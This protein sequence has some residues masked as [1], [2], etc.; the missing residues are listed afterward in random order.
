MKNDEL[1]SESTGLT[2]L[3]KSCLFLMLN[4]PL[5]I[6]EGSKT[7]S[8]KLVT[9]IKNNSGL[10]FGIQLTISLIVVIVLSIGPL[11][12]NGFLL[13]RRVKQQRSDAIFEL[14]A[15]SK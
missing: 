6:I 2:P 7:L 3:Q 9:E 5:A 12:G 15:A 10:I 13:P 8:V 1:I 11:L 14:C 4:N